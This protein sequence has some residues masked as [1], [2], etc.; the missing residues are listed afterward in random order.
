MT[1]FRQEAKQAAASSVIVRI[2]GKE[3]ASHANLRMLT[4]YLLW[5]AA[6]QPPPVELPTLLPKVQRF[7]EKHEG[8]LGVRAL[9][10]AWHAIHRLAGG[11]VLTLARAR[12]RLL[13]RLFLHGL[14]PELDLPSFLRYTGLQA[15]NRFRTVRDQ[16]VRLHKLVQDWAK[17]GT[18]PSPT[19]HAYIDLIFSF[20]LARLGEAGE[21]RRLLAAAAGVLASADEVHSWLFEAYSCRVQQALDGRP[22]LDRLPE[23]LLLRLETLE[24][25]DYLQ[26]VP[27][28]KQLDDVKTGLRLLRLKIDRLREKS[29]IL[30]P[31]E[32]IDPY[33]NWH[34]RFT[35]ELTREI[36]VLP[37]RALPMSA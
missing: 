29:R 10:L 13:E 20:G 7:L 15:S 27:A 21:S 9:W 11:D 25:P 18:N 1:W 5:A 16:V 28:G 19:T 26:H 32:T 33:R 34:G 3:E 24:H 30:E 6:V 36:H 37:R 12:D 22:S 17:T 31:L 2:L 4:A 35:D 23:P 14:T 8:Y